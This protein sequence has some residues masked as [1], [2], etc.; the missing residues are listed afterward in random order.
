MPIPSSH[1]C[2]SSH[3]HCWSCLSLLSSI[4]LASLHPLLLTLLLSQLLFCSFFSASLFL[5]TQSPSLS[6]SLR[7]LLKAS[8]LCSQHSLPVTSLNFI[9][10]QQ[11]Y[12]L[13]LKWMHEGYSVVLS[14]G[15]SGDV[16]GTTI[17]YPH[18]LLSAP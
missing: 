13:P 17:S 10:I 16:M 8:N 6:H 15:L 18:T 9:I 11:I 5:Q 1:Q 12:C 4:C 14:V 3:T 7:V 2:H